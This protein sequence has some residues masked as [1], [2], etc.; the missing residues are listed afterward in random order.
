MAN[1]GRCAALRRASVYFELSHRFR[2]G[3]ATGAYYGEIGRCLSRGTVR[4]ATAR[5]PRS[6]GRARARPV[7]R[8]GLPR[9]GLV[10]ACAAHRSVTLEIER[11]DLTGSADRTTERSTPP[12]RRPSGSRPAVTCPATRV[13]PA[14]CSRLSGPRSASAGV[15]S[16]GTDGSVSGEAMP[17]TTSGAARRQAARSQAGCRCR[18]EEPPTPDPRR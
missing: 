11:S 4:G 8:A 7:G 12:D 6:A 18:S 1:L 9:S 3:T 14:R 15:V 10:Q 13:P 2:R 5:I 16:S 17:Y